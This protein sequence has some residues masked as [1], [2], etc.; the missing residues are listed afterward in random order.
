MGSG[1]ARNNG[2]WRK[3]GP[4]HTFLV[5]AQGARAVVAS[6]GRFEPNA[7]VRDLC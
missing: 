1:N 3:R 7:D 6:G 4:P 5:A 2:I